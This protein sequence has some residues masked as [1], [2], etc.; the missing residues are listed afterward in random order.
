MDG[1]AGER[2]DEEEDQDDED[3]EEDEEDE[4]D[5]LEILMNAPQRSM[6]FR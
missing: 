5:G 1:G 6:D 3:E 2:N 4:D